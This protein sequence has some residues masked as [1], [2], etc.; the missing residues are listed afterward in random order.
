MLLWQWRIAVGLRGAMGGASAAVCD[1][2]CDRRKRR[3]RHPPLL[4]ATLHLKSG[5]SS[6]SVPCVSLACCP[7]ALHRSESDNFVVKEK[8]PCSISSIF[9][10]SLILPNSCTKIGIKTVSPSALSI[11]RTNKGQC[12]LFVLYFQN[13]PVHSD[14]HKATH[15][16]VQMMT[17][18][19]IHTGTEIRD[20][21]LAALSRRCRQRVH[22]KPEP[23]T[24]GLRVQ[25]NLRV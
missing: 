10:I 25:V 16:S 17:H 2:L 6:E 24:Q 21:A 19:S 3:S 12:T 15:K 13:H 22:L 9:Q 5:C 1:H 20:G 8:K 23:C 4:R 11:H 14:V 7:L 18:R